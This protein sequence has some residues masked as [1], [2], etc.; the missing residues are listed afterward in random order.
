M[1]VCVY[2][3]IFPED[4]KGADVSCGLDIVNTVVKFEHL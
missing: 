2:G 4:S 3:I 1:C